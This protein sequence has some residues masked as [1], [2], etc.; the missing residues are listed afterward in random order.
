MHCFAFGKIYRPSPDR[1]QL[2]GG[3]PRE[4]PA[5]YWPKKDQKP[6]RP[7]EETVI[8]EKKARCGPFAESWHEEYV[9]SVTGEGK[10][11]ERLG[12]RSKPSPTQANIPSKS[13]EPKGLKPKSS[14]FL[15]SKKDAKVLVSISSAKY[16]QL[17]LVMWMRLKSWTRWCCWGPRANGHW[18]SLCPLTSEIQNWR[19]PRSKD[20]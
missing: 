4:L 18:L 17:S 15:H 13:P 6:W 7:Q 1:E 3:S 16:N 10:A 19:I 8:E 14:N 5:G 12:G 20:S 2:S 9:K 11:E